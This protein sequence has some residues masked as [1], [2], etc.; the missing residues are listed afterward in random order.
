MHRQLCQEFQD[1]CQAEWFAERT[2]RTQESCCTHGYD[3]LQGKDTEEDKKRVKVSRV[4]SRKHQAQASK[5]VIPVE[6]HR[7]TLNSPS[8]DIWQ[9]IQNVPKKSN[10]TESWCPGFILDVS[11]A[12]MQGCMNA[13]N[14]SDSAHMPRAKTD[15]HCKSRF[16][17]FFKNI[18][19]FLEQ[20]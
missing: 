20:F 15:V 7:D 12:G 2:H 11:H 4:K 6:L 19:H 8:K 3:L 9:H 16:I 10:S 17:W 1:H 14:Y 18:F 13:L 5:C